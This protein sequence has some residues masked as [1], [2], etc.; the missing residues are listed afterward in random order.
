MKRIY[1]LG[2]LTSLGLVATAAAQS[3]ATPRNLPIQNGSAANIPDGANRAASNPLAAAARI[4]QDET[5]MEARIEAVRYLG[6]VDSNHWPEAEKALC[7]TLLFDRSEAV[8]LEAALALQKRCSASKT[9]AKTLT[10]CAANSG[11][12]AEQSQRVR[13]AAVQA[14]SL[15]LGDE[16]L[17]FLD[18]NNPNEAAKAKKSKAN[19]AEYYKRAEEA[20]KTEMLER[21]RQALAH[22]HTS[23][24]SISSVD[25]VPTA[26]HPGSVAKIVSQAFGISGQ[27]VSQD[28]REAPAPVMTPAPKLA[29]APIQ[30]VREVPVS[31]MIPAPKLAPAPIPVAPGPRIISNQ[32]GSTDGNRPERK[33]FFDTLTRALKGK[34][35]NQLPITQV[36]GQPVVNVP[37]ISSTVQLPAT[38]PAALPGQ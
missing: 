36:E 18:S 16:A 9:V 3:P 21:A 32:S 27:P 22:A 29:P 35:T 14:L 12:P 38:A 1:W 25:M 20:P 26:Q 28:V 13:A 8:R 4:K 7:E 15:C 2:I 5:D 33:P 24:V 6:T 10:E 37:A 17:P 30:D 34:Q 31:V 23:E 19:P 11:A